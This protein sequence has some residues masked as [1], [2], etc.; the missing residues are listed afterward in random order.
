MN[1][2]PADSRAACI[3]TIVEIFIVGTPSITS[4][5]LM[6]ETPIPDFIANSVADHLINALA[7]LIWDV[8]ISAFCI[9]NCTFS[10]IKN[11]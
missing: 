9:Y 10:P 3:A 6:V 11:S 7:A 8:V 4:S 5:L 2:I 1:S